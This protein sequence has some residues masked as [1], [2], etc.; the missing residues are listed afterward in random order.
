MSSSQRTRSEFD[1][2]FVS[3]VQDIQ[4]P[5]SILLRTHLF[6]EA[7]LQHV[8]EAHLP[9][10]EKVT[11]AGR[12]SFAQKLVLV[13]ALCAIDESLATALRHLNKLRNECAHDI[14]RT[15]GDADV[16]KLISAFGSGGW[17]DDFHTATTNVRLRKALHYMC[18]CISF[19]AIAAT[20]RMRY[21][22]AT[23][24]AMPPRP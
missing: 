23:D 24:P 10:G 8:I 17:D 2:L 22:R 11:K 13:E 15:L 19:A 14:Q 12:L 4:D 5:I 3:S 1:A 20:R 7:M 18:G 21:D 9:R 16:T 6:A